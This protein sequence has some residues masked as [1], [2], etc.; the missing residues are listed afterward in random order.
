MNLDIHKNKQRIMNE[1]FERQKER[2]MGVR[3]REIK[4]TNE[5]NAMESKGMLLKMKKEGKIKVSLQDRL[6]AMKR[7]SKD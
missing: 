5:R 4:E 6:E 2:N 1:R 3:A 7:F